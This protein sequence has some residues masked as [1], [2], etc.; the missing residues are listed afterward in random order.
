MSKEIPKRDGQKLNGV[1]PSVFALAFLMVGVPF[2]STAI[3]S[4]SLWVGD[5]SK[6][7]SSYG[8]DNVLLGEGD[9]PFWVQSGDGA[10][11]KC[12]NA[13]TIYRISPQ[14]SYCSG[15]YT[16]AYS[17][18]QAYNQ[19]QNTSKWHQ[20]L[21]HCSNSSTSSN[22]GDS[23]YIITQNITSRLDPQR[24]FPSIYFQFTNDISQLYNDR[25]MGDSK[26]DWTIT[27]H[28][29]ARNSA[30]AGTN[31]WSYGYVKDEITISG[32]ESF[33]NSVELN[34]THSIIQIEIDY[35]LDFVEL[36][37]L[38]NLIDSYYDDPAESYGVYM[39]LELNNLRTEKG[40]AW[41]NVGYYNPF[42]LG[43]DGNHEMY[44]D[45]IQLKVDP[46]N[47]FLKFG[48]FAMGAGFWLIALASTPYWDPF[49]KKVKK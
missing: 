45:F 38:S 2:L 30:F 25:R 13:P 32:V 33:N 43:A 12:P 4:G 15:N 16:T 7:V 9:W 34:S 44:L 28:H 19:I 20:G 48:V 27:I 46:F 17:S 36:D 10:D 29:H 21:P 8:A 41:S 14:Y 37:K 22:C 18:F 47:T 35:T 49:I 40:Y 3:V 1:F 24:I 23:G 5:E 42:L 11:A 6:Y 39:T 26:V 31:I